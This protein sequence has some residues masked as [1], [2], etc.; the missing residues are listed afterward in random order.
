MSEKLLTSWSPII[1]W[2]LLPIVCI[3]CPFILSIIYGLLFMPYEGQLISDGRGYYE[4]GGFDVYWFSCIQ[5]FI[6]GAGFVL[7]IIYLAP[8]HT[9]MGKY[10]HDHIKPKKLTVIQFDHILQH[11]DTFTDKDRYE[12]IELHGGGGTSYYPVKDFVDSLPKR[13]DGLI[14]FTDLYAEPMEP[15]KDESIPVFWIAVNTCL[16]E[17]AIPFGTYIP[18]EI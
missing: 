8:S 10:I 6:F 3:L 2:L 9:K 1:R 14:I 17:S 15:L 4:V 7:P 11:V 18:V 16:T 5:A 13:P 12:K